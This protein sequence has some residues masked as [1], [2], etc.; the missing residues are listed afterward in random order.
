MEPTLGL[1]IGSEK[2]S[3]DKEKR[4]VQI[5][6]ASIQTSCV[7]L[8][9][10][11]EIAGG[12]HSGM[13]GGKRGGD[14][15]FMIYPLVHLGLEYLD[16]FLIQNKYFKCKKVCGEDRVWSL[17]ERYRRTKQGCVSGRMYSW[18]W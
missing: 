10:E 1:I 6:N 11:K 18:A 14:I 2:S 9:L 4:K 17:A 3:A 12:L 16:A 8:S 15:M 7:A 5:N 13:T